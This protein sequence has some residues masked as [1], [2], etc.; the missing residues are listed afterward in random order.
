M[1]I[2]MEVIEEIPVALMRQNK[3]GHHNHSNTGKQEAL[4][5]VTKDIVL[6][7]VGQ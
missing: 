5:R 2:S 7:S 1:T 4:R 3:Q 6:S